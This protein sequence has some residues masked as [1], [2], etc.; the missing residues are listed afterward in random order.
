VRRPTR[1]PTTRS[2]S[3][4]SAPAWTCS[5]G[6]GHPGVAVRQAS[7]RLYSTHVQRIAGRDPVRCEA[8]PGDREGL[9]RA[10]IAKRLVGQIVP[11]SASSE[12][13]LFV[14]LKDYRD[15][16]DTL[17]FEPQR[18]PGAGQAGLGAPGPAPPGRRRA[19]SCGCGCWRYAEPDCDR[20]TD[21]ARPARPDRRRRGDPAGADRAGRTPVQVGN[22][23]WSASPGRPPPPRSPAA[24]PSTPSRSATTCS[25]TTPGLQP[26]DHALFEQASASW[27]TQARRHRR[28]GRQAHLAGGPPPALYPGPGAYAV[29]PRWPTSAP[30]VADIDYV[31]AGSSSDQPPSADAGQR[32]CSPPPRCSRLRRPV[33]GCP[34]A[35]AQAPYRPPDRNVPPGSGVDVAARR[36]TGLAGTAAAGGEHRGGGEQAAALHQLTAADHLTNPALT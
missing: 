15:N 18:R 29:R 24:E 34:A 28:P 16:S 10:A 22:S 17:R 1:W 35:R 25:R 33:P 3:T 11:T 30:R 26:R 19:G 20:S 14:R 13:H 9:D 21:R 7:E 23:T 31:N 8:A 4:R 32:P 27:T 2:I 5:N 6:P 12:P 36:A